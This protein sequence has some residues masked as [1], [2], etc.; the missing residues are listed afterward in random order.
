[1]LGTAYQRGLLPLPADALEGAILE[2]GLATDTNL[3]AF[4]LGRSFAVH[5]E[6][7]AKVLRSSAP[8]GIGDGIAPERAATLLGRIWQELDS[9]VGHLR[10]EDDRI[11]ILQDNDETSDCILDQYSR[12]ERVAV[13]AV[14]KAALKGQSERR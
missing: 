14:A 4:Q 10:V 11:V 13:H 7:I 5:P 3:R 8:V 6:E 1:M 9:L 12:L 2:H